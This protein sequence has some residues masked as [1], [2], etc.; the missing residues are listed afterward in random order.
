MRSYQKFRAQKVS[1]DGRNFS[2]KLEAAVYHLLKLREK[3]KEIEFVDHQSHVYL[4]K[5]KV[6]FIPD[7]RIFDYKLNDFVWVEAKGV[8]LPTWRIKRR[9]W[10]FYGPGR[11]EVYKGNHNKVYLHETLE[12][13]K[14]GNDAIQCPAC[15]HVFHGDS[16]DKNSTS[17][18]AMAKH[19]NV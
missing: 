1:H 8:E 16:D 5:A 9:L 14:K 4:T 2:S 7:F 11:L 15:N 13:D 3:A 18:E 17:D 12:I 19:D 6:H 10:P